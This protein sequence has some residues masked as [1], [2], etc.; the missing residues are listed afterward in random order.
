MVTKCLDLYVSSQLDVTP[1]TTTNFDLWMN[2]GQQNIFCSCHQIPIC[3][4]ENSDVM[5][6]LFEANDIIG[7]RLAK[8]LKVF[9]EAWF[10]IKGFVLCQNW[11][12]QVGNHDH[13]LELN[14]FMWGVELDYSICQGMLWAC[15]EQN[16]STCN[17]KRL[18]F[19]KLGSK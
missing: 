11:R 2:K 8:Q 14:Y 16:I 10:H 19:K 17:Q 5:I 15:I 6:G 18:G 9:L 3:I 7:I 4:L 1:T 12:N 13:S